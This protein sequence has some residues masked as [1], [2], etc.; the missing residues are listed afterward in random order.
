M[1]Y[2]TRQ[3]TP[4]KEY[5]RLLGLPFTLLTT[6]QVKIALESDEGLLREALWVISEIQKTLN[7]AQEQL[8]LIEDEKLAVAQTITSM[9]ELMATSKAEAAAVEQTTDAEAG[10]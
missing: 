9:I 6:E 4:P 2:V 5:N 7:L 8:D 10:Q 3:S 1:D